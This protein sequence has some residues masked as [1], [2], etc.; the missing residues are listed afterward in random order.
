[1]LALAD[2]SHRDIIVPTDREAAT[3]TKKLLGY[4]QGPLPAAHWKHTSD[5]RRMRHVLPESRLRAYDV[6]EVIGLLADDDTFCEIGEAWGK[7][8]ITGFLRVEGQPLGVVA[9]SVASPLGGAIEAA[10]ARK[11]TRFVQLLA[12]TQ[13]AHLVVLVDTPGFIVGGPETEGEGGLRAFPELFAAMS[14]LTDGGGRIFASEWC[15]GP[16]S[17]TL[18]LCSHAAQGVWPRRAGAARRRQPEQ[19]QQR[20]VAEWRVGADGRRG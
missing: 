6:R 11:A 10:S 13:C 3:L 7:N 1:M 19:P 12:R 9:S 5:Q 8:L 16:V 4:F 2:S 17:H 20:V 18:T 14:S 15:E